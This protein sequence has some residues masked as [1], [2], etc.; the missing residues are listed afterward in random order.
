MLLLRGERKNFARVGHAF[1]AVAVGVSLYD[2]CRLNQAERKV[3]QSMSNV[4]TLLGNRFIQSLL[5]SGLFLQMGIWVRNFAI[6]LFVSEQ[7]NKDPIAIS[8]ISVAEFGPI[9]LFSF[10]GG[11]FADRWKPKRTMVLC[12]ILSSMSVFAVLFALAFGGWKAIFFA[13]L[14]SSILS[15]FSQPSSM[16]LFKLHVPESLMQIGMSL[17]QTLTSV[18]MILGPMLG[19]VIYLQFGI[20]TAI[21]I[22]GVC[23]LLSAA[24]LA[25]LPKDQEAERRTDS[26]LLNELKL[27][28]RYVRSKPIFLYMAGFYLAAGLALGILNP[29]GIY[30]VTENLDLRSEALQW[31][32]AMNGLGIIVGGVTVMGLSK[33]HSPQS[34]LIFGFFMSG[35]SIAILGTTSMVWLALIAQLVSG[36]MV[37]LIHIACN[38]LVINNTEQD[39]VGRVNGIMS[40]LFIGGMVIDM[41]IV[42]FLKESLPLG[43]IYL[44]AAGLF[45]IGGF[46]ALPLIR[47]KQSHSQ[48]KHGHMMHH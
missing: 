13:T 19:T 41:A 30:L 35:I 27:G 29:M 15:Q 37:P 34:M 2:E 18:F 45:V 17:Y 31:F 20:Y 47:H 21:S 11:A 25:F 39:F 6:L 1:C 33:K 42:G 24:V 46:A 16:K 8:M 28:F 36:I 43:G 22:M 5:V 14:V 9:F 26:R 10:I 7:T 40:P 3:C 38:T 23:F 48:V 44:L 4:R 32:T 12:D